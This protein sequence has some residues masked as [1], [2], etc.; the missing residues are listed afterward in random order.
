MTS[1]TQKEYHT[2]PCGEEIMRE[3]GI[4]YHQCEQCD[5]PYKPERKCWCNAGW[6]ELDLSREENEYILDFLDSEGLEKWEDWSE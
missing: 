5:D 1:T 6:V 3:A 2:T 4:W